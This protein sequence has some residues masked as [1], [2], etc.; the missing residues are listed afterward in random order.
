MEGFSQ[1]TS[2]L[3]YL[4][5]TDAFQWK[6]GA[7]NYFQIMKGVISNYPILALPYFSKPFS[8]ECD[9]SEEGIG[10]VL[11]QGKHPIDF[12]SRKLQPHEKLYSIYDQEMLAIMHALVKFRQYLVGNKFVVKTDHNSLSG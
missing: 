4:T 8:L 3:T 6:E 12:E 5:K 10:E 9:A 11:K 1:L 7:E 2:P